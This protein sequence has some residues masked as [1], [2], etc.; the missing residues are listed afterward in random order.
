M[1]ELFAKKLTVFFEAFRRV[2]DQATVE[3]RKRLDAF[4][5]GY[6]STYRKQKEKWKRTARRFNVFEA[7]NIVRAELKHSA[8]LAYLLKPN[9]HHDQ[10]TLF[11]E[12]FLIMLGIDLPS[13]SDLK[14]TLVSTE[15]PG[16]VGNSEQNDSG[17]NRR[18]DV[19][20]IFPD[21]RIIVIENKI[22]H[23]EGEEQIPD[24]QRW[25][26]RE[27]RTADVSNILVFLTP[28]GHSPKES[29]PDSTQVFP[30]SYRKL[31]RWLQTFTDIPP[32]MQTVLH[33]YEETCLTIGEE[34][35]E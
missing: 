5:H 3:H 30:L 23:S 6:E 18:F 13:G 35:Y 15:Y 20:I 25:L 34:A 26:H 31:G 2:S 21:K 17:R 7:T 29:A 11:L 4:F 10:G 19:I 33:M 22:G 16:H 12:S 24:Y 14:K 9:A 27:G 28:D 8:I 32:R 1:T